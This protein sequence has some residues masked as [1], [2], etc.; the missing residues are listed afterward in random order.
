MATI[1]LRPTFDIPLNGEDSAD[2]WARVQRSVEGRGLDGQFRRRFAM[3]SFVERER[4][5][6]SPWLHLDL[7][8]TD[9]VTV[10]H[11]RFSPHPSI[12]TGLVFG[13][14]ALTVLAFFGAVF[15]FSQ[16]LSGETPWGCVVIPVVAVL[17][18]LV[19]ITS[20]V[21]QR[22]AHD[23][24]VELKHCIETAVG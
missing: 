17:G 18:M 19:W 14:L 9:E 5:F 24:M 11:G 10:L 8:Q 13:Y 6:W 16:W 21:G 15:G 2:V 23:E 4:H 3:I 7:R 12:W 20:Q 22:L 1:R